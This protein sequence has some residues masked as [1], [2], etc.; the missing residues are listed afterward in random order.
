MPSEQRHK[1]QVDR[2]AKLLDELGKAQLSCPYNE[3]KIVI[4][5]YGAL[6]FFQRYLALYGGRNN[7]PQHTETH[8]D[9]EQFMKSDFKFKN[10]LIAYQSLYN[11][12]RNARYDCIDM[13]KEDL[14]YAEQTYDE[15]LKEI[16]NIIK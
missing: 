4:L 8:Y 3:W 6:H 12:S 10:I 15:I 2:N 1:V 14:E 13:T 7:I 16:Q 11:L 5:F 9:L